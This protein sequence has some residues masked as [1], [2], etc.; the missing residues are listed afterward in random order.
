MRELGYTLSS[1]EHGSN[2][3]TEMVRLAEDAGFGYSMV[4]DHVHP[5]IDRRGY[6]PFV[7]PVIAA[8]PTPPGG[9]AWAHRPVTPK[10][11]WSARLSRR[12]GPARMPP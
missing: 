11:G 5:W 3:L 6:S 2:R 10:P 8:L 1:E 12:Q 7:W 9:S 4:S